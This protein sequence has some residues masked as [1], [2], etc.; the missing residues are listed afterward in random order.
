M[1]QVGD[2]L[3]IRQ[4]DDMKAEFGESR[5]GSIQCAAGFISD[6]KPLCGEDFTVASIKIKSFGR[7]YHSAERT[8]YLSCALIRGYWAISEDMLEPREDDSQIDVADDIEIA[9]LFS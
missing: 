7:E 1:Y 9:K 4:W 6:M 2:K 5:I 3:R 8:E